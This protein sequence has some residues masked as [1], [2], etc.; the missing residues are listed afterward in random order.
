MTNVIV[1]DCQLDG[2]C[3][4][5]KSEFKPEGLISTAMQATPTSKNNA[6][7]LI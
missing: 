6:S 4:A 3:N 1:P 2:I 5:K 7:I